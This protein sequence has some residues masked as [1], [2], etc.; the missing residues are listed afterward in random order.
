MKLNLESFINLKD[1]INPS[2]IL[3]TARRN[4]AFKW[5]ITS[6]DDINNFLEIR[7]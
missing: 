5:P 2:I 3:R 6:S 1:G 7:G 4:I